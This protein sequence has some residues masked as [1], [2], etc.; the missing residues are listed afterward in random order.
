M[1]D[2]MQERFLL[3]FMPDRTEW[4]EPMKDEY[5]GGNDV[6]IENIGRILVLI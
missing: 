3:S 1:R 5:A 6:E 2:A 4:D